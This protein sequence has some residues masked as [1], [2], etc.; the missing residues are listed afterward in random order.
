[1]H[2]YPVLNINQ[3]EKLAPSIMTNERFSG[4]SDRYTRV[5]TFEVV[6]L[7]EN[8]GWQPVT[9]MEVCARKD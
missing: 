3:L 2:T 1:M 9:A 5:P 4:V 7:M 8:E 6:A